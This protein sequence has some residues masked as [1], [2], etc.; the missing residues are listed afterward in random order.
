HMHLLGARELQ[1]PARRAH[2]RPVEHVTMALA[3]RR[4]G[5]LGHDRA[6]LAI[7]LVEAE[8]EADRIETVAEIA[9]MRQQP[10]RSVRALAGVLG[11]A[12]PDRLAQ[13]DRRITEVIGAVET[14]DRAA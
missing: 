2:Q 11:D 6:E 10:Y 7:V 9:Q 4:V 3:P 5:N 13:V 12:L 1:P 8:I 14:G